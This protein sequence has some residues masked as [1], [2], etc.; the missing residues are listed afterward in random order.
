MSMWRELGE[1]LFGSKPTPSLEK[2]VRATVEMWAEK[3]KMAEEY[4]A[5]YPDYKW[6][7]FT[8]SELL[9]LKGVICLTGYDGRVKDFCNEILE[10]GMPSQRDI[11]AKQYR[12]RI[13]ELQG[14]VHTLEAKT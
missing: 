10:N 8:I 3:Q 4:P 1:W 14:K 9:T 13:A 7:G 12:E 6:G 5:L 11:L 2:V